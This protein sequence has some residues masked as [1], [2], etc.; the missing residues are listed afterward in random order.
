MRISDIMLTQGFLNNVS[1][2]KKGISKLN[3]QILTE[4]KVQKASDDPAAASKILRLGIQL[5]KNSSYSQN[6]T[7]SLSF[8][9][10]TNFALESVQSEVTD[11]LTKLTELNN[12]TNV[13][14]YKSYAEQIDL[15]LNSIIDLANSESEGRYVF[16]GTDFSEKPYGYSADELS[17]ESK[18]NTSGNLNVKVSSNITQTINT[19][20]TDVFGTILSQSG[21]INSTMAVGDTYSTTGTVYNSSKEPYTV[22]LTYTK[23]ADNT[24][25][26][27]YDVLDSTNTSIYTTPPDSVAVK[28]DAESGDLKTIN[29]VSTD[30]FS[31]KDSDQHL[32]FSINLS[33]FDETSSA[34][35]S[36]TSVNQQSDVFNTLMRIRDDLLNGEKPSTEDEQIL[37]DFN[38]RILDSITKTG[39]IVN[40]LTDTEDLLS[41]QK[42]V[43]EE[44]Y[45][46]EQEVDVAKA[47][48]DLQSLENSL[49]MAYQISSSV[50]TKSLLDYL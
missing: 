13:S 26:L 29:G 49:D 9:E 5:S 12:E 42:S 30:N 40:K 21:N 14:N 10:E 31:I 36:T 46:N 24:Y 11:V 41:N 37:K 44:L 18:V 50:M 1:K 35:S 19:S 7:N 47:I 27:N 48:V 3:T 2:T 38:S 43:Y 17:I 8:L 20:G 34:S 39:N 6:I 22:S 33:K 25:S 16:G 15:A 45:A 23:T 28:F 4:Q 32:D